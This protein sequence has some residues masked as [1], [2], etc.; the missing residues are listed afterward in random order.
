MRNAELLEPVRQ[1]V[2]RLALGV[3][4]EQA[5]RAQ[6]VEAVAPASRARSR[7]LRPPR[8]RRG[9]RGRRAVRASVARSAKKT[10]GIHLINTASAQ[11][12]PARPLRPPAA[13][14]SAPSV[15]AISSASL[16]P[17]PA[18]WIA[19]SGFQPTRRRG[20]RSVPRQPGRK[21]DAGENSERGEHLEDP[22]CRGLRR[23]GDERNDLGD[24]RE[25]RPVDRRR[26][27][28]G[29]AGV[30]VGRVVRK[31]ARRVHVGIAVVNGRDAAVL[32]VRPRVGREEQRRGERQ[33]SG[34][35]PPR[36]ASPAEP[37]A[38]AARA[39][40]RR[41]RR[42][43]PRR[44]ARGTGS[45]SRAAVGTTCIGRDDRSPLD[46]RRRR[47]SPRRGARSRRAA[48]SGGPVRGA[49]DPLGYCGSTVAVC[50]DDGGGGVAG[51]RRRGRSKRRR[52]G[53]FLVFSVG[54]AGSGWR[55]LF[56]R[57]RLLRGRPARRSWD[58]GSSRTSARTGRARTP[59]TR[60]RPSAPGTPPARADRSRSS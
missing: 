32:P 8:S 58:P 43:T 48:T 20:V 30:V 18:K 53:F 46:P 59:S 12:A 1:R 41:G 21:H 47:R 54:S 13:S 37:A 24:E 34:S 3:P 42:Q 52:V 10:S 36:R 33:R 39:G 27:A 31:L 50:G 28:P 19:R 44:A 56:G 45:P 14:A 17:P 5:E 60:A 57:R 6:P 7:R 9:R 16:W 29:G 38:R 11:A 35:P 26:V 25:R 22:C 40:A 23:A 2:A 55:R 15:S 4:C 49:I 51:G